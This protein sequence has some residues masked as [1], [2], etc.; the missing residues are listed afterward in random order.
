MRQNPE[1]PEFPE[2][3]DDFA[4]EESPVVVETEDEDR[5]IENHPGDDYE[6]LR[7][8]RAL[9][10][11]DSNDADAAEQTRVVELDEDEYR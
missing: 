5:E 10:S 6:Q 9:G 4:E 7:Q 1:N 11:D 8:R 3:F 2:D